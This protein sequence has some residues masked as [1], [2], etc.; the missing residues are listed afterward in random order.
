MASPRRMLSAAGAIAMLAG[1]VPRSIIA[2]G[3]GQQPGADAVR[4]LIATFRSPANQAA[5]GVDAA[6]AIRTRVQQENPIRQ[7]WV[8]P[9]QDIN[10]YLTSSGYKADSALSASDLKELA[11]LM[12]ADEI[13]DGAVTRTGNGVRVEARLILARDVSLAQPLA[14][15]EAKDPAGA[16]R[17]IAKELGDARRQL[18]DYRKCE[19]ALRDQKYA[20]AATF[21]RAGL[22]KDPNGNLSRLCLMSAFTYGKMGPDS[23]ARVADEILKS[24][25]TNILA[26]RNVVDAYTQKGDTAKSVQAMVR[27]ARLDAS[28]RQPLINMLAQMG[29]P[30]V[31]MPILNEMLQDNPGDPQLLRTKWLL[32]LTARRFKE[33]LTAGEEYVKADTAAGNVDYYRRSIVAALQDSQPQLASQIGA[34]AVQKFATNAELHMLYAQS[35]RRAGQLQQSLAA[36][37]RAVELNPNVENGVP[38]I[39]VT[40]TELKQPE[41]AITWAKKAVAAGSDKETIGNGLLPII[42]AAVKDAQA[43]Q[44]APDGSA[45]AANKRQA[46]MKAYQLAS[47]VDSIAPSANTKFF[48]GVSSFYVGL[49][50]LQGLNKSKSCTET[51]L[52]EDMWAASQI[53]MPQGAQVDKNSAGQI[54]GAINQ[55]SANIAPAKKAFCKT[56]TSRSGTNR[57]TR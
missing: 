14:P 10:N 36:A 57:G 29:K 33:A 16:A 24:D 20:E 26:L 12:R 41:G 21:A 39:L 9:R 18:P 6:E 44:N 38:L 2:Q 42:G 56:T 40:Y 17:Q 8:L 3:R 27:L 22:A 51:Q 1:G 43:A 47:T 23:V 28:V 13:V 5:L 53:A 52:V 30:E 46:W 54:L 55:Y 32:L 15:V 7:V 4:I 45:E 37:Q 49:D 19:A 35:L 25:S 34:R 31:A 11:K 50:A 48:I